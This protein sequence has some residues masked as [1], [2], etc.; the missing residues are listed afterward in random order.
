MG[1]LSKELIGAS[2]IPIILSILSGNESYGYEIIQSV[3]EISNGHIEYGDG[4][5]YPVLHKLEKKGLIE[6][7]WK[8]ADTGRK[9]KYYKISEVGKTELQNQKENWTIINQLIS[10]LWDIQPKLT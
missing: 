6:S 7:Y 5:M 1:K 8:I 3:K 10:K 4:T 2:T 9:R